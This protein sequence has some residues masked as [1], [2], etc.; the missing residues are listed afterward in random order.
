MKKNKKFAIVCIGLFFVYMVLALFNS[1]YWTPP[2]EDNVLVQSMGELTDGKTLELIWIP[3]QFLTFV[4]NTIAGTDVMF[5]AALFTFV[6]GSYVILKLFKLS[7][8]ELFMSSRPG[9]N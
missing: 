5:F 7:V 3:G 4:F 9:E 8:K 6:G 1:M 2:Y